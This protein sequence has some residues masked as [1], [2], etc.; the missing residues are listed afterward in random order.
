MVKVLR[1]NMCFCFKA[2]QNRK[3]SF[4]VPFLISQTSITVKHTP[5][6]YRAGERAPGREDSRNL[7]GNFVSATDMIVQKITH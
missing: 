1:I 6:C 5:Y 2:K 3:R 7:G 4:H